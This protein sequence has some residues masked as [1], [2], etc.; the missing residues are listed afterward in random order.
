MSKRHV[1]GLHLRN[2]STD[3]GDGEFHVMSVRQF[4]TFEISMNYLTKL[5][6]NGLEW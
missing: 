4:K 1:Q 2:D 6:V 5:Q 3:F